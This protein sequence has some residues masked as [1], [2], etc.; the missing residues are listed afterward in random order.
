MRRAEA[1][2][3]DVL[4][5]E[6]IELVLIDVCLEYIPKRAIRVQKYDMRRVNKKGLLPP[7]QRFIYGLILHPYRD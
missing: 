2:D 6:L 3:S 4:D 7:N 1:E 5:N